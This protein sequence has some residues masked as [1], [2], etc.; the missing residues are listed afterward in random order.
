MK[1]VFLD[2][3]TVGPGDLSLAR[4]DTLPLVWEYHDLTRPDQV[5]GRISDAGIV[6]TNKCV[7][8]EE[9]LAGAPE[10]KY[11]CSAA[12]GFNHIDIDAAD[13]RGITVS[14]VRNYATP[15]V[16]QH[17]YAL[18][19]A[20]STRLLDYTAAVQ[21]GDWSE[22]TN[23]CLLDYPIDEIAGKSLGII[24]YGTLGRAVAEVAPALGMKVLVC[25][26]LHGEPDLQRV[27]LDELLAMA[28]I[29]SLHLPLNKQTE[30]FIG[31][32][33]LSLMKDN[34]LLINTGRGGL[35]D[36]Q[37]LAD[38]LRKKRIGGAG[39]DVLS[40]EPPDTSNP[41][42]ANDIPNL[43]V[44][45]HTAWASRQSRQRLVDQVADNIQSY[46]KGNA[47]HRVGNL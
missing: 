37:A 27:E 8:N 44:T 41:L 12:T 22:S 36:E 24:G 2:L 9:M 6:I 42:L 21:R 16:V 3:S 1:A 17:V 5:T 26:H 7:L 40:K 33:E 15:S 38:A 10:L 28:D 31:Q 29:I 45:P 35:V 30:N 32:R 18:I 23:F 11:I 34:A 20:L 46:L 4:F 13:R 25:Q 19:L 39:F 47:N 43:I 14:N